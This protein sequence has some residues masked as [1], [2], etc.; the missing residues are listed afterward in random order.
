MHLQA[1]LPIVDLLITPA[2]YTFTALNIDHS[3]THVHSNTHTHTHTISQC[4]LNTLL[5]VA[6]VLQ[7]P[8]I[9][10]S[11]AAGSTEESVY[12]SITEVRVPSCL[13]YWLRCSLVLD[14][15]NVNGGSLRYA[16]CQ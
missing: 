16:N 1:H 11:A 12:V 5:V 15:T 4:E 2:L 7:F 14:N 8:W 9:S 10:L 13:H 6:S 3:S